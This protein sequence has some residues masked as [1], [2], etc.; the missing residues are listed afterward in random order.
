[1]LGELERFDVLCDRGDLSDREFFLKS[2]HIGFAI[3]YDPGNF[4]LRAVFNIVG[5]QI[6][7]HQFASF[8]CLRF[9]V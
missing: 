1:M 2:R 4:A 8:G 5:C 3:S 6:V 9:A 7:S